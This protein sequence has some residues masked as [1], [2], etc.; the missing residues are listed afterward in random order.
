[1]LREVH[2]FNASKLNFICMAKYIY[3]ITTPKLL[4]LLS[5]WALELQ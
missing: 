4:S 3:Q 2:K 1:M 5:S